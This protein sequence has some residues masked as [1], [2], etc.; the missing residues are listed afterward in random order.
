MISIMWTVKRLT[1]C[2]V[3]NIVLQHFGRLNNFIALGLTLI[4]VLP[5]FEGRLE[6]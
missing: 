6:F 4:H 1:K 2:F 5:Q 3:Q